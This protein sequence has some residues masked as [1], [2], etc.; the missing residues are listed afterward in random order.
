M[1]EQAEDHELRFLPFSGH[2]LYAFL[3][4]PD[5]KHKPSTLFPQGNSAPENSMKPHQKAIPHNSYE[6]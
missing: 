2:E 4:G 5:A 6:K 3:K 1:V